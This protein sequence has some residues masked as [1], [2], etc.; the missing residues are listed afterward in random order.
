MNSCGVQIRMNP[1]AEDADR[2]SGLLGAHDDENGRSKR[3]ASISDLTGPAFRDYAIIQASGE[4]PVKLRKSSFSS[5]D[6]SPLAGK[7]V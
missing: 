1:I 4:K 3:L 5:G 2:L 7:V 6:A